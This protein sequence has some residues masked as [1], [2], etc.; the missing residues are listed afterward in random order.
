[1]IED[2]QNDIKEFDNAIHQLKDAEL[3]SFANSTLPILKMHL[4]SIKKV[5]GM[6][7]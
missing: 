6:V 7:K 5:E 2:H 3:K 1:M 4:E